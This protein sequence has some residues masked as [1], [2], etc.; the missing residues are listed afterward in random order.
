MS[1]Q[2]VLNLREKRD[3]GQVVNAAFAFLQLSYFKMLRDI[4][5]FA[6]PFFAICGVCTSLIQFSNQGYFGVSLYT[7][8][9]HPEFYISLVSRIIGTTILY[10]IVAN[11]IQQYVQTGSTNFDRSKILGKIWKQFISLFAVNVFYYAANI[12]SLI[13]LIIPGVY[14]SV[15]NVL[16]RPAFVLENEDEAKTMSIGESFSESRRLTTDNWWR[17]FG[18][19]Y[20]LYFL[21]GFMAM[22]FAIPAIILVVIIKLNSLKGDGDI[23]GYQLYYTISEVISEIGG[24]LLMPITI[25]G[26]CIHYYSLKETKDQTAIMEDIESIGS[27]PILE[28]EYEGSY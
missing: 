24:S 4:L 21:V 26:L 23:E 9:L 20:I 1:P 22:I 8:Y 12:L 10:A 11:Y 16:A 15:A 18:L 17:T 5:F 27:Q 14:F 28:S 7:Y 2:K 13:F 25:A 3:I 6:S 19:Y